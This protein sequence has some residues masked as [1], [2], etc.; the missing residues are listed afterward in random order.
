MARAHKQNAMR[1][2]PFSSP[3]LHA[4]ALALGAMLALATGA[5]D[6]HAQATMPAFKGDIEACGKP[7]WPLLAWKQKLAGTVEVE[8]RLASDGSVA[9]ARISGARTHALLEAATLRSLKKCRFSSATVAQAEADTWRTAKYVWTREQGAEAKAGIAPFVLADLVAAAEQGHA[10]S[11]YQLA[12]RLLRGRGAP[13]DPAQALAWFRQAAAGGEVAAQLWLVEAYRDGSHGVERNPDEALSILTDAAARD[14]AAQAMLGTFYERGIGV[15]RD[16]RAAAGWYL[17]AAQ[18]GDRN[19]QNYL[20]VLYWKGRGVEQDRAQ[21]VYWYTAAAEQGHAWAQQNLA[22]AL[23][24][25]LGTARDEDASLH[26]LLKAAAQDHL[27]AQ[28]RL[29]ER[30]YVPTGAP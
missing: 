12:L 2:I 3:V 4:C 14:P 18:A 7:G 20:G 28:Q 24:F 6:A 22:F 26:W 19:A 11:Q 29:K 25:G 10:P 16:V 1:P 13:A 17:Q 15:P 27:P 5:R 30:R 23:E 9:E 8:Y 21:A